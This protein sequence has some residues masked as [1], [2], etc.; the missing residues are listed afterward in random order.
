VVRA[1]ARWEPMK[2]APPVMRYFMVQTASLSPTPLAR[3]LTPAAVAPHRQGSNAGEAGLAR[4]YHGCSRMPP[5]G[6]EVGGDV[7]PKGT[8]AGPVWRITIPAWSAMWSSVWSS[9]TL[10]GVLEPKGRATRLKRRPFSG[11]A[12]TAPGVYRNASNP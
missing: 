2:P 9:N 10:I 11:G 6:R 7:S 3:A 12:G 8:S 5:H 1:S 4:L